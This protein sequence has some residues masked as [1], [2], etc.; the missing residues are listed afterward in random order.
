MG[1]DILIWK[2]IGSTFGFVMSRERFTFRVRGPSS[3]RMANVRKEERG[4]DPRKEAG[5]HD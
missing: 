2:N 5:T 1:A 4:K 3:W